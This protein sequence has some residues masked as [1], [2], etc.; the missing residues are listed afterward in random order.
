MSRYRNIGKFINLEYVLGNN[1][2]VRNPCMF[3]LIKSS[4]ALL[5]SF[6]TCMLVWRI[7][8]AL[9]IACMLLV[10][11]DTMEIAYWAAFRPRLTTLI[12]F[13]RTV[14]TLFWETR[15]RMMVI[16][17][18]RMANTP[19]SKTPDVKI[20]KTIEKIILELKLLQ[21]YSFKGICRR[22]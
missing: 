17:A 10:Q 19:F 11:A 6:I 7:S 9:L 4:M 18:M 20:Y 1:C 3:R 2:Y 13:K 21:N 22:M 12:Y 14:Q 16:S 8:R 5:S 15:P